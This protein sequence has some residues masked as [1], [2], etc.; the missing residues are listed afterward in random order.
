[1]ALSGLRL[2]VGV[3]GA[4]T[5]AARAEDGSLK[6]ESVCAGKTGARV[7]ASRRVGRGGRNGRRMGRARADG[8]PLTIDEKRIARG[9]VGRDCGRLFP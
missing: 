2:T 1:M 3:S 5:T 4:S 8:G 7:A 6:P 9:D